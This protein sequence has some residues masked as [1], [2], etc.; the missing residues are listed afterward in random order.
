MIER[1]M[2]FPT[3]R[4]NMKHDMRGAHS[5]LWTFRG[6]RSDGLLGVAQGVKEDLT[7]IGT[8]VL[9]QLPFQHMEKEKSIRTNKKQKQDASVGEKE[10]RPR[11]LY[12]NLL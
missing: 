8:F 12:I 9:V 2:N 7:E 1:Y 10:A 4:L 11:A 3:T 6:V 5:L